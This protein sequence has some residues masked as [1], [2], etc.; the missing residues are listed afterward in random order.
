MEI[1]Q[2]AIAQ[3]QIIRTNALEDDGFWDGQ[4]QTSPQDC[5]MS[6]VARLRLPRSLAVAVVAARYRILAALDLSRSSGP[7][8]TLPLPL[9]SKAAST[10]IHIWSQIHR[11]SSLVF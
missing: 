7:T 8:S 4:N 5:S 2:A 10:T 1:T 3:Q 11:D 6:P 9:S